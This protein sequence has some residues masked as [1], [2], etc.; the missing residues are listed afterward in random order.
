MYLHD[1]SWHRLYHHPDTFIGSLA[2]DRH[3]IYLTPPMAGI[4]RYGGT[5]SLEILII[6]G[7]PSVLPF[8]RFSGQMGFHRY[9]LNYSLNNCLLRR[10]NPEMGLSRCQ[11]AS[12]IW[13]LG[14]DQ[15]VIPG[16]AFIR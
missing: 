3:V 4:S 13:T 8:G 14:S 16:V 5:P 10:H 1:S 12:S 9:E 2:C 6:G 11:T 15:P 7:L